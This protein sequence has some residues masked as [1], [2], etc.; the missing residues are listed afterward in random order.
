MSHVIVFSSTRWW[1]CH[2]FHFFHQGFVKSF[3]QQVGPVAIHGAVLQ[4]KQH[5]LQQGFKQQ[6]VENLEPMLLELDAS[7]LKQGIKDPSTFVTILQEKDGALAK[8][9]AIEQ[10][11]LLLEDKMPEGIAWEEAAAVLKDMRLEE[12]R[13]G[14]SDSATFWKG[15]VEVGPLAIKIALEQAKSV[16]ME[17]LPRKVRWSDVKEVLLEYCSEAE[18]FKSIKSLK[19]SLQ[20]IAEDARFQ[21][22][23]ALALARHSLEKHLPMEFS[24]RD[25]ERLVEQVQ[26][27]ELQTALVDPAG[28]GLS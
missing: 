14:L 28:Q 10:V 2:S 11:R 12:L 18:A 7:L 6:S 26:G 19:F 5:L 23:W 8:S 20:A 9:L 25:V 15:L 21:K 3:S 4:L 22:R 13:K 24:W 17:Q 27:K 1:H 16:I